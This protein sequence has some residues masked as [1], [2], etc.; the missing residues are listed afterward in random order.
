MLAFLTE[1]LLKP[2]RLTSVFLRDCN[3]I[4]TQLS[5]HNKNSGLV[6]SHLG[7]LL[8]DCNSTLEA[9]PSIENKH[10]DR[11]VPPEGLVNSHLGVLS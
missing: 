4:R 3:S 2:F 9:R 7:V 11:S 5:L 8:E 6:N 1:I 10:F